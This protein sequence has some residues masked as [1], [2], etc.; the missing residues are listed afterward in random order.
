MVVARADGNITRMGRQSVAPRGIALD[1]RPAPRH[2]CAGALREARSG[3]T[4]HSAVTAATSAATGAALDAAAIADHV[5]ARI[6]AAA[7]E[8]R[9]FDHVYV[10]DVLPA[11]VYRR[12]LALRPADGL[13]RELRKRDSLRP[14]GHSPRLK[15]E[16][17]PEFLAR[18]PG[19]QQ[20][21]WGELT[22]ALA[23]DA[24]QRAFRRKFAAALKRRFGDAAGT[25]G[26]YPI[27]MLLRD[28]PGYRISIHSD[29]PRKGITVQLYL[30]QD[31]RQ[32]H[33]GTIFHAAGPDGR[34][35][36]ATRMKFLP[37]S[38]YAFPV[39]PTSFHSLDDV[40]AADGVRH[41]LM[42][43]YYVEQGWLDTVRRHGKRVL[44]ALADR[45]R[46]AARPST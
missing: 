29:T 25:V 44:N 8:T 38:L 28:E 45:A 26:L 35:H 34:L 24:V 11:E 22:V 12:A 30:P 4:M 31:E 6:D 23:S 2:H 27:P 1:R 14:D 13:Y 17:L 46:A 32:A 36:E 10:R 20:A 43:T 5:A 21:F 7:L 9:P 37:N 19:E 42:L 16:L 39:A 41:S 33:L 40:T 3:M 18:L 15:F